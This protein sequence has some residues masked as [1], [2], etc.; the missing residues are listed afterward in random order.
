IPHHD[1]M[2]YFL[3]HRWP[4]PNQSAANSAL[5]GCGWE[6][7]GVSYNPPWHNIRVGDRYRYTNYY[8]GTIG[9][10]G[11]AIDWAEDLIIGFGATLVKTWDQRHINSYVFD[12]KSNSS[13]TALGE[14]GVDEHWG[15]S[16][17]EQEETQAD[18]T[19]HGFLSMSGRGTQAAGGV[20][21]A[22]G[23]TELEYGTELSNGDW[24]YDAVNASTDLQGAINTAINRATTEILSTHR[25]HSEFIEVP[26]SHNNTLAGTTRLVGDV[27]C[28]GKNRS[29]VHKIDPVGGSASTLI[30]IAISGLEG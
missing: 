15:I 30:E 17:A 11:I 1:D 23:D 16:E 6:V 12:V 20:L 21:A 14:R 22:G 2:S 24:Y 18:T 28:K 26:F 25:T 9:S 8:G 19:G 5:D 4:L 7:R 3:Q 27:T 13:I 10:G 29:L